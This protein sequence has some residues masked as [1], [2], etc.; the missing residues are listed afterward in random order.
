MK[1]RLGTFI[2]SPTS[3]L[4]EKGQTDEMIKTWKSLEGKVINYKM[5]NE[6]I[7]LGI[8]DYHY[9]GELTDREYES[10]YKKC[11]PYYEVEVESLGKETI[12][13]KE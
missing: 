4:Y 10:W 9:S 6:L 1:Q 11:N 5:V 8:A 12:D 7:K 3:L 13:G 2:L